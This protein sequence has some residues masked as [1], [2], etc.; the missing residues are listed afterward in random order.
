MI[1][2]FKLYQWR[3]K[4]IKTEREKT[5]WKQINEL[6]VTEESDDEETGDMKHYCISWKSEST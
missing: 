1:I 6:Y 3:A 4:V 5:F 2:L